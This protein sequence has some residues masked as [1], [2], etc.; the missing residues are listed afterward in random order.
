VAFPI[1]AGGALQAVIE[2]PSLNDVRELDAR[3]NIS[4]SVEPVA[5]QVT[6]PEVHED[7]VSAYDLGRFA[8]SA[9]FVRHYPE[10]N[11]ILRDRLPSI[12]TPALI[13]AG[14]HDDLVPWSNNQYLADTMPNSVAHRLDAG[15][16]A[17]EEAAG[18]YGRLVAEWVVGGYRDTRG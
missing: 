1:E 7:Y 4:A 8:E 14:E 9:R 11:E 17:W 10:Q 16:F 13:L 3:A 6:E 15:H 2:A 5:P 18:E 12:Q